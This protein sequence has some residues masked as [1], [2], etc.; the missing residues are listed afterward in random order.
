MVHAI[1]I[2]LASCW[3]QEVFAAAGGYE[4]QGHKLVVRPLS[5]LLGRV[6]WGENPL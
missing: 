6:N 4:I 5:D 2:T 1:K 3:A